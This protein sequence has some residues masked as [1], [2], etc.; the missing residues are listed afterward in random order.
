MGESTSERVYSEASLAT[1]YYVRNRTAGIYLSLP[2]GETY[3]GSA[4]CFAV[5]DR[6]FIATAAHN[7]EGIDS[8][9]SFSLFSANRSSD[10]PLRIVN[11]NYNQT[12][13]R[14]SPDLAGEYA[15]RISAGAG[16]LSYE[17]DVTAFESS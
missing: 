7:F 4:T 8:G 13:P 15:K 14:T 16:V 17:A 5:G 12:R 6:I 3:I 11:A 1:E 9:G 2:S 10:N